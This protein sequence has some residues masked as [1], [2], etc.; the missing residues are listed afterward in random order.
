MYKR[1]VLF[2]AF[3]PESGRGAALCRDKFIDKIVQIMVTD[4]FHDLI[5]LHVRMKED[6]YKREF[7]NKSRN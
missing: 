1:Q 7:P 4:L 3:F 5:V 6:V 2:P